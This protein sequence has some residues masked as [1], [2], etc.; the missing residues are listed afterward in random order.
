M[1]LPVVHNKSPDR[2]RTAYRLTQWFVIALFKLLFG[3]RI[4][5]RA[6]VPNTG[7]FILA[8]NHSSW[9][10]PPL[11]GASCPREIFY[12][13]K[14]EL[15]VTPVLGRMVRF[16]NSIPIRRSGFDRVAII[17]L[18]ELL[19]TGHGIII[20]A[21]GTRYKDDKLHPPKLGVGMLAAKHDVVIVPVHVSNSAFL[22]K[23][24]LK[25]GLRVRFGE[26]IKVEIPPDWRQNRKDTYRDISNTV[27]QRI[28]RT[29]SV[30]PPE[31]V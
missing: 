12:A 18:G 13:A 1:E 25:R 14:R 21:E 3:L 22:G 27:M 29:G 4:E 26:S 2:V 31:L 30:E 20:F 10:D 23:Q 6:N 8:S 15:F 11:I 16:Y 9:F 17:K 7:S 5:G 19:D 24:L 28:A